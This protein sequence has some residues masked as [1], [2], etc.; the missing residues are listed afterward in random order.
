MCCRQRL[1]MFDTPNTKFPHLP[2]HK[3]V[4]IYGETDCITVVESR[5]AGNIVLFMK[6]LAVHS[7]KCYLSV[8]TDVVKFH[9]HQQ[10]L[11]DNVSLVIYSQFGQLSKSWGLRF[12]SC[13]IRGI[14]L[15]PVFTLYANILIIPVH[16]SSEYYLSQFRQRIKITSEK[17]EWVPFG[18]TMLRC[19]VSNFLVFSFFT[20]TFL[21]FLLQ[22]TL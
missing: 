12:R 1:T 16:P 17:P 18:T 5:T 13:Y 3:E 4:K 22:L 21:W 6:R 9:W 15:F 20:I 19:K 2:Q 8:K 11:T 14:Y 7:L 10:I